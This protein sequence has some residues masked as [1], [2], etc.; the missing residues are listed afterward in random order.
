MPSPRT[1]HL[2]R[3]GAPAGVEVTSKSPSAL[4]SA[5]SAGAHSHGPGQHVA[6]CRKATAAAIRGAP[7]SLPSPPA[8]AAAAF[9]SISSSPGVP[10][11]PTIA[12]VGAAAMGKVIEASADEKGGA[13]A[14]R[15][16][17]E[18]GEAEVEVAAVVVV[19]AAVAGAANWGSSRGKAAAP[20][21]ALARRARRRVSVGEGRADC[22]GGV[23]TREAAAAEATE[24]ER[25]AV[26][27]EKDA[28]GGAWLRR[29]SWEASRERLRPAGRAMRRG[30]G[31]RKRRPWENALAFLA[32]VDC[33]ALAPVL[34]SP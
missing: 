9:G 30:G 8:P 32:H 22:G 23:V 29:V 4:T 26:V 6:G 28:S 15:C 34:S 10:A 5:R 20:G 13:V 25:D 3:P 14:E 21:T 16:V 31:G 19:G 17:E 24:E 18:G 33:D 7:S 12:A 11:M 1:R 27:V 2:R